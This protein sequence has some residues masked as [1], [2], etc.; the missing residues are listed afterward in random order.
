MNEENVSVIG[1]TAGAEARQRAV[2]WPT[3]AVEV[4]YLLVLGVV[5]STETA[6]V[7]EFLR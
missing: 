3:D 1:S 6:I 5:I 2:A 7:I 4:V